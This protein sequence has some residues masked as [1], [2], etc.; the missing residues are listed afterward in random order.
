MLDDEEELAVSDED[1]SMT[2]DN[3][4]EKTSKPSLAQLIIKN[5]AI[6]QEIQAK[7][8]LKKLENSVPDRITKLPEH[9]SHL[10][11]SLKKLWKNRAR[12]L[13]LSHALYEF[14]CSG[15]Q[16]KES[17]LINDFNDRQALYLANE[18][19]LKLEAEKAKAQAEALKKKRK[20]NSDSEF[21][22]DEDSE[23]D[24]DEGS[25]NI[26]N[27]RDSDDGNDG[28]SEVSGQTERTETETETDQKEQDH[29]DSDDDIEP[30]PDIPVI[31][32]AFVNNILRDKTKLE[33]LQ[34]DENPLGPLGTEALCKTLT[35]LPNLTMLNLS[36]VNAGVDGARSLAD[37]LRGS[38]LQRTLLHLIFGYNAIGSDGVTY[39]VE[40]VGRR[41]RILETLRLHNND[42]TSDGA[43]SVAIELLLCK[44]LRV[45]DLGGNKIGDRG[46]EMIAEYV[47]ENSALKR[48]NLQDNSF[49][50][51]GA[52]ALIQM[53]HLI[54]Q[55]PKNERIQRLSIVGCH[56]LKD[57]TKVQLREAASQL[58]DF[59]LSV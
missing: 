18:T 49:T 47:G 11:N 41:C 7:V 34:M 13:T 39:I 51:R 42:V 44:A 27:K 20:H 53:L 10:K 31:T 5:A 54:K 9:S 55:F 19:K 36:A 3:E 52:Q 16:E 46:I 17:E 26:S 43:K 28:A 58:S 35:T 48:I 30:P 6:Q 14:D 8:E 45:L 12:I 38:N 57:E 37:A 15:D 24:S 25:S 1:F 23:F 4:E 2:S 33:G 21:D 29:R 59:R 56:R 32:L 40:A 50:R 22:S